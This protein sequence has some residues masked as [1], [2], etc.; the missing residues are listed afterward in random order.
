VRRKRNVDV[1][2]STFGAPFKIEPRVR[3]RLKLGR[4]VCIMP[5]LIGVGG[6]EYQ[7]VSPVGTRMAPILEI[8][9]A[10]GIILLSATME[11]G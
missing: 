11:Y 8:M 10:E 9:D 2:L 3:G 7:S 5:D 4:T 1:A 6:E